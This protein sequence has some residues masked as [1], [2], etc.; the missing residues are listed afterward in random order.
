VFVTNLARSFYFTTTFPLHIPDLY[1]TMYFAAILSILAAVG[2]DGWKIPRKL[3]ST[4]ITYG[5]LKDE[6]ESACLV[7]EISTIP[8]GM[9]NSTQLRTDVY[10]CTEDGTRIVVQSAGNPFFIPF[11]VKV[12]KDIP[13]ESENACTAISYGEVKGTNTSV[14]QSCEVRVQPGASAASTDFACDICNICE[15]EGGD[16]EG[17]QVGTTVVCDNL[18]EFIPAAVKLNSDV[19]I[20]VL[21][22]TPKPPTQT[23]AAGPSATGSVVLSTG[24]LLGALVSLWLL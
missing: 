24:A 10:D 11:L 12:C 17:P 9:N 16:N 8:G 2:A 19:C 3:V 7:A 13:G 15:I 22:S 21:P 20:E 5:Q 14:M 1:N 18:K 4:S 6:I 23:P